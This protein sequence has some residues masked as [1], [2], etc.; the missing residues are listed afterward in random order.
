L[1][2]RSRLT[3]EKSKPIQ[4]ILVAVQELMEQLRNSDAVNGVLFGKAQVFER[5]GK[6]LAAKVEVLQMQVRVC[7]ER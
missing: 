2:S 5:E 7:H 3:K 6:Q 1:Q 4:L